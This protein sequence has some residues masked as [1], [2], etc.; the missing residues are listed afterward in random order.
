MNKKAQGGPIAYIFLVLCFIFIW[1]VWIGGWL[2]D[3]G[4]QAI[5][6]GSLTGFEA[7][8]YAN[9]NLWVFL[10]LFL[11]SIGYMWWSSGQ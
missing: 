2:S 3:V 9:L 10:G 1:F 7:F 11:G 6:D 4:D 8:L 5:I